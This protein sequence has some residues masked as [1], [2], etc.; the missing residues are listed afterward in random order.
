MADKKQLV[1]INE[2]LGREMIRAFR[3]GNRNTGTGPGR[4][5][6]PNSGGTSSGGGSYGGGG[7]GCCCVEGD[8]LQ[9]FEGSGEVALAYL[10][11]PVSALPCSCEIPEGVTRIKFYR[12]DPESDDVWESRHGEDDDDLIMCSYPDCTATSSWIWPAGAVP[13]ETPGEPWDLVD[14][15][16]PTCGTPLRPDYDGE[17]GD[18]A[19]TTCQPQLQVA[20]WR[21]TKAAL[22][23][24]CDPSVVEFFIGD[25]EEE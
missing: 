1:T 13:T 23:G 20:W 2:Q 17:D 11:I 10:W 9:P 5:R 19:D 22:V 25:E 6:F 21:A 15:T 12:R 18:E 24:G 3:H 7:G 8:C 14:T 16:N 4:A